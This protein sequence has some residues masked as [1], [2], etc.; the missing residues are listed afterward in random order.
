MLAT[1]KEVEERRIPFYAGLLIAVFTFCEFLSGMMWARLADVIGRRWSLL[2]G[3][4][5]CIFTALMFGFA[6]SLWV[7]LLSRAI[8]G[9]SNP[10]TGVVNTCVGEIVT[11]KENQAKAFSIIPFFRSMG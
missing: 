10:N 4:V 3:C 8:G 7:A 2:L 6:T 9:L 1:F 5:G 11:K